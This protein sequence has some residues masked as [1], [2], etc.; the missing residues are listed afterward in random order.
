MVLLYTHNLSVPVVGWL[1]LVV[2]GAWL[3]QR[4]WR[5]LGIWL[6]GQ[7]ALLLAYVPWLLSQAPSGTSINTPPRLGTALVWDIWQGYFA[8]AA[9]A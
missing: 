8:P 6:G 3:W 4:R 9:D 2:G 7:V 5:W 1:N